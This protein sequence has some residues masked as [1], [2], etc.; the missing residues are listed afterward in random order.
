MS[1]DS[2]RRRLEALEAR[3]N[4]RFDRP[5]IIVRFLESDGNGGPAA[6]QPTERYRFGT[7]G[8]LE[9]VGELE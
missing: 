5:E 6:V 2:I 3:R 1:G 7:D 9:L 4:K 8:N